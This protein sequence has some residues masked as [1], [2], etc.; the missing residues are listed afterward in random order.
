MKACLEPETISNEAACD[1][2]FIL[3]FL[4][5]LDQ[6]DYDAAIADH[7]LA[8]RTY[9]PQTQTSVAMGKGTSRSYE[10]TFSGMFM[11]EKTDDS[12]VCDT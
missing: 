6:A 7:D 11:F 1:L 2:P 5:P 3:R 12:K 4:E 10:S 8:T 9:S